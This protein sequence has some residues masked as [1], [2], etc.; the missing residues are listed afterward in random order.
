VGSRLWHETEGEPETISIKGGS[1]DEP[2][3]LGSAIHIWTTRKLPAEIV[4]VM[5][6][7]RAERTGLRSAVLQ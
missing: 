5:G 7:R 1:L 2:V 4:A 6:Q 3:D